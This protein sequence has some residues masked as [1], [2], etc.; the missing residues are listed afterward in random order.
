[1]ADTA[2]GARILIRGGRIYDHDGDVH[3][4][5]AAD[6]LIDGGQHRA[7]RAAHRR[8]DGAEVIDAAG[9]LVVPGFV[10]AH[11]H[12]HD[13]LVKGL[14]E[15]MPFDIWTLHSNPGNYGPRSQ[16]RGP[17]AHADRR[18]RACCATAS[19][20]CRISSPSCRRTTPTVDTVLVGLRRGRHPRRCSPSRRATAPPLDIAPFIPKDLPE[21]IRKPHLR[22][23]RPHREAGAGFRRRPD[24]AA[25]HESR[26]RC[27][28]GRWRRRRRSA[29]RR[30]CWK[31][32]PRCR[33]S[34]GCRCSP[35][36]TRPASRRPP[37]GCRRMPPRCSTC[38]SARA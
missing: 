6:L 27:K 2:Q 1:M 23:R 12:S 26:R 31:A 29:A 37:R 24:Q 5:A 38:S 8:A 3:Q 15:E 21:A 4:P 32:W 19:P 9:K 30:N 13:V 35:M 33:A 16:R 28:P 14:F 20:P 18:R 17:A 25:R 22:R 36:S 7:D 34:T 11:Y 10:N